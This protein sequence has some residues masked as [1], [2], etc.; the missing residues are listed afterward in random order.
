MMKVVKLNRRFKQYKEHGHTIALKF[1]HGHTSDSVAIEKVCR[2]RLND[3][4][5][6]PS[7]TWY[8]YYGD[9]PRRLA[10]RPFWITFRNEADLTLVMLSAKIN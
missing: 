10:A 2:T 9:R 5:W 6:L 4:G 7:H 1:S 8:S 3:N